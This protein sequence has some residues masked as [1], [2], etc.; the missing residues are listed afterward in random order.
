M[1]DEYEVK[2]KNYRNLP[3]SPITM[4]KSLVFKTGGWRTMRPK[5]DLAKCKKCGFCWK[6]CPENTIMI[7]D[8]LPEVDY[9]YCKGCGVC[10]NECPFDAI[11]MVEEDS[12]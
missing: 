10:Y 12:I 11:E 6:F 9:I 4:G 1:A 2:F 3:P 7:V 5:I 8:D